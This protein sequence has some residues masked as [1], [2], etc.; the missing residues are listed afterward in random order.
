[1]LLSAFL[2]D[3]YNL[4]LCEIKPRTAESYRYLLD[5][6]IIPSIGGKT[7]SNLASDDIRHMLAGICSRGHS[8]T[9]EMCYVLLRAALAD[10]DM[11]P[12]PMQKVKRPRHHQQSPIAWD[13]ASMAT[14]MVACRK[15]PHG[16]A[17]SLGLVLGLRRGEICGLRWT[18]IDWNAHEVHICNQR[19]RLSS[20]ALV[21]APPKSETSVRILPVPDLLFADLLAARQLSGYICTIQPAS[22]SRCHNQIVRALGLPPTPL[23]GLRHS[24]ATSIIRHGGDMRS[25]QYL[26]GHAS[27]STTANRYTHP[28]RGML[29]DALARSAY[30]CYTDCSTGE[31]SPFLCASVT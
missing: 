29:Y 2:E 11:S 9:A 4:H 23:H 15:H 6:Y 26:L 12:S 7:V 16:L 22:L 10:L 28:D 31:I 5:D 25:L 21:D 13:D 14:Y 1:M 27:M 20:G 17:L 19:M 30:V 8:R 3:W 18:D 24:M